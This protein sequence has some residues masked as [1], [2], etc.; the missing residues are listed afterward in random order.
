MSYPST[1]QAIAISKTGGPEVIEKREISFPKVASNNLLIKVQYFGVNFIDTY[2]RE[3]VYTPPEFP[4][5]IGEEAAGVIVSLPT[6][7]AV[8]NDPDYKKRGYKEG[9]RVAVV[10]SAVHTSIMQLLTSANRI[11]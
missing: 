10:R 9:S 3:G 11:I 4:F 7:E 5:V 2:Y 6:D 8:L 1:V